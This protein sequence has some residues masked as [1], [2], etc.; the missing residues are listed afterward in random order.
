[1]NNISRDTKLPSN[2]TIIV[3]MLCSCSGNIYQHNTPYTVKKGDTYN[4]LLTVPVLCACPTTKQTAK[5]I[6][7]LLVYTVN[8]GE[9]VKSIGEAY[10]VD[11]ESLLEENDCRWKLR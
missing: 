11:E 1:M 2:K 6:T 10:G 5:K 8:Y 9:T 7:S 3:P 4:H